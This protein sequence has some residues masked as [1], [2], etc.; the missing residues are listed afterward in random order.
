MVQKACNQRRIQLLQM[1][2]G[3]RDF[4]TVCG[5]FEKELESVGIGLAGIFAGSALNWQALLKE[6]RDM[7][8]DGSHG[9]PPVKK[10]SQR[11]A[12][13]LIKSGTASRYQ[14]V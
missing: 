14:Y 12:M 11:C 9:R 13:L 4:K 10:L 3:R 6:C 1:Q 2:L 5:V 7:G 8:G